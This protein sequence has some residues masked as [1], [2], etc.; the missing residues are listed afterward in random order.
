VVD[1]SVQER[2]QQLSLI[3]KN[4]Q[5]C[6]AQKQQFQSQ[7]FE[8]DNALSELEKTTT[9][10]KIVGNIMVSCDKDTLKKEL[11]E[12]K[13]LLSL[14]VTTIS[15]QEEEFKNRAKSIR[16]EVTK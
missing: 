6:L 15:E 7:L 8:V 11:S 5:H 10:F 4:I 2:V 1:E 12:K 9:A 14:R 16:S 13:E 3:D